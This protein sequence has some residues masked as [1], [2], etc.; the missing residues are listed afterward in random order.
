MDDELNQAQ[1][2]AAVGGDASALADVLEHYRGDLERYVARRAGAVVLAKE[3]EEDI[4]QS[5]CREV[6][7]RLPKADFVG[8]PAGFR[9]WLFQAALRKVLD[10]HRYYR[11]AKR[12]VA[13][14]V[15]VA[16]REGAQS[17]A[18]LSSLL[19]ALGASSAGTPS[20]GVAAD[21]ELDRL[22]RAVASLGEE[23]RLVVELAYFQACP[24][25][26]I[27]ELIGRTE[28]AV[29]SLLA[30]ALARIARTMLT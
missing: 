23:Q 4:V 14:E 7:A 3:S 16:G 6:I 17:R 22:A 1:I 12:D 26:E 20:E 27:A 13:R 21:E 18:A 19:V 8:G 5:A 15:H 24:H 11:Q 28:T 10:R 2:D 30:R 29:R 25:R 9:A